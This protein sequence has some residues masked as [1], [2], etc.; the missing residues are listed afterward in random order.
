MAVRAAYTPVITAYDNTLHG[1]EL[2]LY[3]AYDNI[4]DGVYYYN[5]GISSHYVNITALSEYSDSVKDYTGHKTIA[6]ISTW[7]QRQFFDFDE[8]IRPVNGVNDALLS[9]DYFNG[10]FPYLLSNFT[11]SIM[12]IGVAS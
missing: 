8:Y 1:Q 7:R 3:K 10:F 11:S 5:Q 6:Q 2:K 4:D 9:N 12:Y